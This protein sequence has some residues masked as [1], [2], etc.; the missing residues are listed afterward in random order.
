MKSRQRQSIIDFRR[1][2]DTNVTAG[3]GAQSRP[4]IPAHRTA[5]SHDTDRERNLG[6]SLLLACVIA[7]IVSV[8]T[9]VIGMTN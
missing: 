7:I 5:R 8:A 1:L 4:L 6:K 3:H 9:F 2:F